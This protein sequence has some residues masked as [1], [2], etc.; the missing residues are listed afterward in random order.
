MTRRLGV[1]AGLD[2]DTRHFSIQI[3]RKH[4]G[5][6]PA[7]AAHH[8][9][10]RTLDTTARGDQTCQYRSTRVADAHFFHS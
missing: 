4:G 7:A 3:L 2:V 10:A 1:E 8:Q 6:D 5:L 9:D